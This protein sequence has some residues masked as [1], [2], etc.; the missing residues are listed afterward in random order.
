MIY[1]PKEGLP[2]WPR[3]G[4]F[5]AVGSA[6]RTVQILSFPVIFQKKTLG[7]NRNQPVVQPPLLG[8]FVKKPSTFFEINPR[9]NSPGSKKFANRTLSFHKINSQILIKSNHNPF[10]RLLPHKQHYTYN[11]NT[12]TCWN[13]KL[14]NIEFDQKFKNYNFIIE[15]ILK[16]KTLSQF[17]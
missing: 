12:K 7:L 8:N 4:Q 2:A 14:L 17:I 11:S 15:R 6:R 13:Q 9:S 5:P 1:A 3:R 10:Y 16:F